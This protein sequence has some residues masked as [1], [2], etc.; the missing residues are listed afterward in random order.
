MIDV[1][2]DQFAPRIL[3]ARVGDTVV[4]TNPS[5]V[6]RCFQWDSRENGQANVVFPPNGVHRFPA[7]LAAERAA[8]KYKCV[9]DSWRV[10]YARVF[11]HPYFAVTD[12]DG[13]F[14]IKDA[15]VGALRLVAWHERAGYS[16]G[17]DGRLG[18]P[19]KLAPGKDGRMK[20]D[21]IGFDVTK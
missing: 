3:T 16:G 14:E 13:A 2:G 11:D 7:P 1:A 10:G 4:V 8:C 17:K 20:M 9:L 19:V 6:K 18:S 15:P 12:A 21:P 5:P